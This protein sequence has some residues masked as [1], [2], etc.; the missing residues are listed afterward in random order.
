MKSLSHPSLIPILRTSERTSWA[1]E[2]MRNCD[3]TTFLSAS[4]SDNKLLVLLFV[5]DFISLSPLPVYLCPFAFRAFENRKVL[6]AKGG[7]ERNQPPKEEKTSFFR[8][9][10]WCGR[11]DKA[12]PWRDYCTRPEGGRRRRTLFAL[13]RPRRGRTGARRARTALKTGF[14]GGKTTIPARRSAPP[15][16]A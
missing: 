2:S 1:S 15:E 7:R 9:A 4:I 3:R 12:K 5:R 13:Y 8:R 6:N 16:R 11:R 10:F 14:H